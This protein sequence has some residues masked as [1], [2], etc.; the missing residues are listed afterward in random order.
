VLSQIL[1]RNHD[2]RG[3]NIPLPKLSA[4]FQCIDSILGVRDD[5]QIKI[6]G[7]CRING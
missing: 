1:I 2:E 7:Q 3:L 5:N 4:N 6:L